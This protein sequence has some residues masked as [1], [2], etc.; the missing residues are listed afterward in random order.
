MPVCSLAAVIIVILK[1][2]CTIG[3]R[4]LVD[5]KITAG[6]SEEV[7]EELPLTLL[8]LGPLM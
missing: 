8:E 7:F 4:G 6:K 2:T 1:L 5:G 3:S